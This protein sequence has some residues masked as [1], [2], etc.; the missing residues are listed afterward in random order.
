M[1]KKI[2]IGSI[3]AV[4]IILLSSFSSVVGKVSS[5]DELVEFDVEFCGLGKKHTVKLTHEEADEVELL[6]DEIRTK[7]DAV[8]SREEAIAIYKEAIV[9]LDKYGLLGDMNIKQA[10]KLVIGR[11]QNKRVM[12]HLNK[13]YEKYHV[14]VEEDENILCL[15]SGESSNT[16]S[17]GPFATSY[18]V[19]THALMK[20]SSLLIDMLHEYSKVV[21]FFSGLWLL[22][23]VS[24]MCSTIIYMEFSTLY[25]KVIGYKVGFGSQVAFHPELV[26]PAHGW[27]NT[28]GLKGI[29]EWNGSFYGQMQNHYWYSMPFTYIGMT[30]FT[31][32]RIYAGTT[33]LLG[34]ALRVKLGP[35]LELPDV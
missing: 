1:K 35:E 32:L 31:G 3:I 26:Y 25:N 12:I 17:F 11:H 10:Q 9:E 29:K 4:V 27:L 24:L 34:S 5:D 23:V 33:L 20:F 21:D 18:Y 16:Y 22:S 28:I 15:V 7:L 19:I 30:G 6:F 8:E 2:L 13:L 14:D